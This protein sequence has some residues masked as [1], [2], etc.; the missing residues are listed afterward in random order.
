MAQ[1]SR[2]EAVGFPTK[3]HEEWKYTDVAPIRETPFHLPVQAGTVSVD[4]FKY[5]V[6]DDALALVFVDGILSSELSCIQDAPTG[7]ALHP[8]SAMMQAESDLTRRALEVWPGE[9]E[10][11][12]TS[13][14]AALAE[15]GVYLW[16]GQGTI[17]TPEI[18]LVHLFTDQAEGMM[19]FPRNTLEIG[20]NSE[21]KIVQSFI[22]ADPQARY[23]SNVLTHMRIGANARVQFTQIQNDNLQAYHLHNTHIVQARASQLE[24][25]TLTTGGKIT[26]NTLRLCQSGAGAHTGLNGLYTVRDQQLVDNHTAIDHEC[27]HGSSQQ[28][29]KGILNDQG[30]TVFNGKI[31]VRPEAQQTNAYQ[32]NRN[33]LLSPQAEANTKPQLEIYADDVKCSHG[34][35]VGP[36]DANELFYL[37]SRGLPRERAISML[38]HGFVEDVLGTVKDEHLRDRLR[39][40]LTGYFLA[41]EVA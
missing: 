5:L 18:H 12:F 38:S 39:Q 1:Y 30:K 11:C 37:L 35:S 36:L 15:E 4:V 20:A 21:V 8:L 34:A 24:A 14:N 32:L 19:T 3:K 2:F 9:E 29:Y 6:P 22:G 13:L 40:T 7:V 26:R 16:V 25:F 28:L 41:T 33:L 17:V 23:F 10:D 31:F 27:E